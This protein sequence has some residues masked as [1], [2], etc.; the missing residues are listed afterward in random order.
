M[1]K[2]VKVVIE[3]L[4]RVFKL[5]IKSFIKSLYAK[6][7]KLVTGLLLFGA[8]ML[9][10]F[11]GW[12]DYIDIL[13]WAF[14]VFLDILMAVYLT[15][16]MYKNQID[17]NQPKVNSNT[18]YIKLPEYEEANY[19]EANIDTEYEEAN[20]DSEAINENIDIDIDIDI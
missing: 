16:K 12:E 8:S 13:F 9:M 5:F 11:L 15:W 7:F 17:E 2:L 18:Y 1:E 6:A 14:F 3:S 19:E 4:F 20:I 10:F